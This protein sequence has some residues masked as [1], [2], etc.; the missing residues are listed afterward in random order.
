MTDEFD[1]YG[2]VSPYLAG[3]ARGPGKTAS[4]FNRIGQLVFWLLVIVIVSARIIWY[5]IM[6]VFKVG[7]VDQLQHGATFTPEEQQDRSA[8]PD[9]KPKWAASSG[10]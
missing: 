5:P 7:S 4:A 6:P 3:S 10:S 8:I 9:S 2:E 1:A